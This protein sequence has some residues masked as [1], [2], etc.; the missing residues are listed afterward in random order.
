MN[1]ISNF[2][3]LLRNAC[4]TLTPNPVAFKQNQ[5][6]MPPSGLVQELQSFWIS[7]PFTSPIYTSD[8]RYSV[9][10]F[11]SYPTGWICLSW[12]SSWVSLFAIISKH[13]DHSHPQYLAPVPWMTHAPPNPQLWP[14]NWAFPIHAIPS[15]HYQP[16]QPLL[17]GSEK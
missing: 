9:L 16:S 6:E 12:F 14:P 3:M 5:R 1:I 8:Y 10:S 13:C 17:T 15:T 4:S 2:K 7:G 11:P